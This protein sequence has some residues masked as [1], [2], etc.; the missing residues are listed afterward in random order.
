MLESK[1]YEFSSLSEA[2]EK[3]IEF[4]RILFRRQKDNEIKKYSLELKST[5]EKSVIIVKFK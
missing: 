2:V 1:E 4:K 5:N 3:F